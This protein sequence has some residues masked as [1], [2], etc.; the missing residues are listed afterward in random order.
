MHWERALLL[1]RSSKVPGAE[2]G[3]RDVGARSTRAVPA[4]WN[5]A[6]ELAE[7]FVPWKVPPAEAP[8]RRLAAQRRAPG[9]S[10]SALSSVLSKPSGF[11]KSCRCFRAAG[12][13]PVIT[14]V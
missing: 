2:R 9:G 5:S 12:E 3:G 14:W 6:R 8:A 4:R 7:G 11:S 13:A 10:V 1:R